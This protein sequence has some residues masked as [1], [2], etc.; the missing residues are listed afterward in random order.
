MR[1]TLLFSGGLDS[2]M[3]ARLLGNP[4]L[5]YIDDGHSYQPNELENIMRLT[6]VA[7]DLGLKLWPDF[8]GRLD[9]SGLE[10]ESKHVPL[11]NLIYGAMAALDSDVVY[12]GAVAGESSRDK[13]GRFFKLVSRALSFSEGRS[14]QFV[15][16]F[17]HLTKT[18]LVRLYLRKHS[19]WA[20]RELLRATTSCYDPTV[21][22]KEYAGCGRCM[23]CFRR[24]VA[25]SNNGISETYRE[26]PWEWPGDRGNWPGWMEN[27]R[28]TYIVEWPG[29]VRN[30]LDALRALERVRHRQ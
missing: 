25:L 30:N 24:W 2:T 7:R 6:D 17:R 18:Q 13:A 28:R 21:D 11:R 29:I 27:V 23:A 26:A 15:A 4:R 19:G 9:L 8:L 12:L 5:L 1:R 3:A 22:R 14:I 10:D 16:P 20:D